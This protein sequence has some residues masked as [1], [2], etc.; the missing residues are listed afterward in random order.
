MGTRWW[1]EGLEA[2]AV[3][4][5]DPRSKA[6]R[7]QGDE[8]CVKPGGLAGNADLALKPAVLLGRAGLTNEAPRLEA[9]LGKTQ[10]TDRLSQ[11]PPG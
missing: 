3:D 10:R 1:L 9:V 8:D 5:T 4:N 2:W 6:G 7:H 11:P